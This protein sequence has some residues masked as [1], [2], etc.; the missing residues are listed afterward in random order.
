[1][2]SLDIL[3]P[4]ANRLESFIMALGGIAGQT[5]R[6]PHVVIADQSD[7][8]VTDSPVVQSLFR[9]LD[10]RGAAVE[11]H[12]RLPRRGIA[13]QR[14]FLLG[15]AT[16][17]SV[18]YLDDDVFMEHW[19]V[20]ELLNVLTEEGCGFV[21]AFPGGLSFRLDE[22]KQQQR[23]E[24]WDGPV[25]PEAIEPGSER[26]ELWQLHRAANLFHVSRSIPPG[27]VRRYKVTWIASCILY[28]RGKL[29]AIGGFGFWD[30]LPRYHSGEEVLVQNLL[31]RKWGGCAIAPSGTYHSE[32][33]STVLNDEGTVDGHAIDLLPEMIEKYVR[34]R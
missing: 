16:T 22:R 29:E 31:M 18:L 20:Q 15:R 27:E 7:R 14:H 6:D 28:D 26:W 23:I 8:K 24:Y 3:L 10:A 25:K 17:P 13:E 30:R 33:P 11:Y 32:L 2:S 1:M 12:Y 5:V 4:T 9:M 21:G 19:V 34:E